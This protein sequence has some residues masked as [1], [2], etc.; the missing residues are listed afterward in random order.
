MLPYFKRNRRLRDM[1]EFNTLY[2]HRYLD[3]FFE[4]SKDFKLLEVVIEKCGK[5]GI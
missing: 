4:S 2:G 3:D 5:S 1:H